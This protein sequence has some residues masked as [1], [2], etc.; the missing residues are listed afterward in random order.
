MKSIEF[1]YCLLATLFLLY[2]STV[3]IARIF[4]LFSNLVA[5]GLSA[6]LIIY[7]IH[8]NRLELERTQLLVVCCLGVVMSWF[9][10][11]LPTANYPAFH[12]SRI[13]TFVL[14]LVAV[15]AGTQVMDGFD[16]IHTILMILFGV[17]V[18][19]GILTILNL[20]IGF[21]LGQPVSHPRTFESVTNPI[22]RGFGL[23]LPS[24]SYSIFSSIALAVGLS[25]FRW[26]HLFYHNRYRRYVRVVVVVGVFLLGINAM[27]LQSRATMMSMAVVTGV[28]GI[29]ATRPYWDRL[30][31]VA[32]VVL[33][34]CIVLLLVVAVD[35]ITTLFLTSNTASIN[36]RLD[37]YQFAIENIYKNPLFGGG[38]G[39]HQKQ[40]EFI[41]HNFWLMMGVWSGLPGLLLWITVFGMSTI[42]ALR[43][44]ALDGRRQ[45][46]LGVIMLGALSG[47]LV[48][49]MFF[50]GF[51]NALTVLLAIIV[52]PSLY[53]STSES[54][55]D[56][57]Y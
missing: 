6:S 43:Y 23:R 11:S 3:P 38:A 48:G 47:G 4:P 19:I 2:I 25:M 31:A 50:P 29:F 9:V 46:V 30:N 33:S 13:K 16:R 54:S 44:V 22:P 21:P 55:C 36:H 5:F 53:H 28:V 17:T 42:R 45:H 32:K 40:S 34:V 56:G 51:T 12:L 27:A 35:R 37:Q 8:S 41:I 10:V 20:T 39:A 1:E 57:G 14:Y 52:G 49:L 26:P 7:T 15:V 18:S 24:G